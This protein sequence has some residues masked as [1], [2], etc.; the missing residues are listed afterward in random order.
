MRSANSLRPQDRV[1]TNRA[2]RC[3]RHETVLRDSVGCQDKSDVTRASNDLQADCRDPGGEVPIL[4]D[5]SDE[6]EGEAAESIGWHRHELG[7]GGVREAELVDYCWQDG[8]DAPA[9]DRVADPDEG[10]RQGSWVSEDGF[11]LFEVPGFGLCGGLRPGEVGE[12]GVFFFR[13][14]EFGGLGI[15]GEEE[16]GVDAAENGGDAFDDEDPSVSL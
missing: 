1:Y 12:D 5:V 10:E 16:E 4:D 11:D 14:E 15:V 2:G 8:R 13:G 6:D 3:D 7:D 9:S